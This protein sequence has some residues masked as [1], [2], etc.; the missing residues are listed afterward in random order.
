MKYKT[1][2]GTTYTINP[3]KEINRG[4]EG[5]I[6]LVENNPDI[7]AKIFHTP[8]END[9]EKRMQFMKQ[10]DENIFIIPKD[11]LFLKS[12]FT[13]YTMQYLDDDYFPISTIFSK[14][15]CTRNKIDNIFKTQ[16]I[17][18]L[19][20]AV[21]NAHQNNIVLG[22]LNQ[23]N[24]LINMKG[25]LKIIDTD[26]FA[27][28]VNSHSGILLEEIRD[29]FY[30]GLINKMSD[31][32]AFSVIVFNLLTFVHPYKG[33]HKRFKNLKDR[34][35]NRISI[36]ES[37]PEL[38]IP[39]FYNPISD[40]KLET[41]FK[42][43]F[44][45]G[46]RFLIPIT[47]SKIST[48]IAKPK[49]KATKISNKDISVK[50]ILENVNITSTYFNDSLGY[51]ETS[52]LFMIFSAKNRGYLSLKYKI[53]KQDFD[54][55]FIG[56]ENII[57]RKAHK[58]YH[59]KNEQEI[60]EI[61]NF[62]FGKNA[63][64]VQKENILII[65]EKDKMFRLFI[66]EIFNSSIKS[67]RVEVFGKSFRIKTGLIQNNGSVKRIFYN[68]GKTLSVVKTDKNIKAINQIKNAGIMQYIEYNKIVTDFFVIKENKI[69]FAGNN[70]LEI[71]DFC[72]MQQS[73]TNGLILYPN[74]K[75]I[76]MIRT[77]DFAVISEMKCEIINSRTILNYTKSGIIASDKNNLFLIN[78]KV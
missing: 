7:V 71:S 74:N 31:Y 65:F 62:Y 35:I 26:S 48:T 73:K 30:N 16:I 46:E 40:N 36:I 66:D 70:S 28:P 21:E 32:F 56:N 10:L 5:K 39:N 45:G 60:I 18:K 2:K 42:K 72:Y 37:S 3:D 64:L 52:S 6:M 11:L 50:H 58:L 54:S 25:D 55:I 75:F 77:E 19:H 29:Y 44:I 69:V 78:S 27:T 24:I 51:V 23:F 49:L 9:F 76:T 8:K 38:K 14:N 59:Y 15:F 34:M 22:D 20:R 67:Q 61:Q 4:G 63:R 33:I 17:K 1:N 12:T 47:N 68:S 43:I 53:N 41:L 13:G 57:L